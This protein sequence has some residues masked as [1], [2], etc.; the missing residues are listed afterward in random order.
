VT[1][2]DT[3]FRNLSPISN[4]NKITT[5]S[6]NVN[7][8][9]PNTQDGIFNN[10]IVGVGSYVFKVTEEGMWLGAEDF[11]DAPF[12]VSMGGEVTIGGYLSDSYLLEG[13]A[14]SDINTHTTT[15][16]G[17]KITTGSITADQI[18][19]GAIL[20]EK[21]G[22]NEIKAVNIAAGVIAANHIATGAI[23]GIKLAD[24]SVSE[25]KIANAA[26]TGSKIASSTITDSNIVNGTITG[27]K[28]AGGTITGAKIS[29][30]TITGSNIAGSTITADKLS[31]TSLSAITATLGSVTS[32]TITG[33]VIVIPNETGGNTGY[34]RWSGGSRIWN[35]WNNWMGYRSLGDRHYFYGNGTTIA[36]LYS[37]AQ[38][39]FTYGISCAGNLNVA[40]NAAVTGYVSTGADV[41]VGNRIYMGS[42]S[43][44][45]PYISRRSSTTLVLKGHVDPL[46]QS[47]YNMG[48]P[49]YY[50]YYVNCYRVSEHSMT[51]FD[52]PVEMRDGRK[53]DDIEALKAIKEDKIIDKTTGRPFLDKRTFPK[54]VMVP[55]S[56]E[57]GKPYKRDKNDRPLVPDKNGKVKPRPDADGVA[58]GQ[59]LSLLFGGF[60]QLVARVE[61]LEKQSKKN[62]KI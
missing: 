12:K 53:L 37:G 31:V 56:D 16:S 46:Y 22:A 11:D 2:T 43:T 25:V 45:Y 9:P 41:I 59:M 20:S 8:M 47:T 60:K 40:A 18:A 10:L 27:S 48:G 4:Y 17:G 6:S 55:A 57:N 13:E 51:S 52:S 36:I 30:S 28:I 23:T 44:S 62:V 29:S 21:I 54:D 38:S 3:G 32:G 14:A 50:W 35:D 49:T 42:Y 19:A 24:G 1:K 15:I 34:L 39:Y 33:S 61:E 5:G 7:T 58:T 26:V